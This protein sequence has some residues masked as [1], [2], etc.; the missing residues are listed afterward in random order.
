[1]N[2]VKLSGIIYLHRI[3]DERMTNAI[4]RNLTMFRNL[5]GDNAFKN[6]ILATTF[7]DE[8]QD[9]GKGEDREKQLLENSEWWGY[10]ASKGS[11]T[12]RFLNTKE[13]ALSIIGDLVDLP[14]VTLQIQD[15][16]VDQGLGVDQ[17][18]AGEALNKE[19]LELRAAYQA[20]LDSIRQEKEQAIRDRDVQLEEM[21]EKLEKEKKQFMRHLESEQAALHADR[22]EQQRRMEQAF[23]DQLL[24]LERERKA[25]ERKIEDLETRL[26]TERADSNE[27]FQAAMAE[28]SRVVTELRLEMENRRAEDRAEF[29]EAIRAIEGRQRTATSEATRWRTEVDRLN[30]QIR[31]ASVAQLAAQGTERRRMEARIR[32]LENTRETSNTNFWDVIGNISGLGA[33]ILLHTL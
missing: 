1:M 12:R 11:R 29:D 23:N 5:C 13:S 2:H 32:E 24:R 15:E 28:S 22:C 31:D 3:K 14:A 33:G 16:I 21:L 26:S 30:Q 6:V 17:T 8:L 19:L 9:K 20:Q 7:W 18:T 27:R 4:M 25:R 10:M